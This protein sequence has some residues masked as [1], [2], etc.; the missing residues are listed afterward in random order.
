MLTF[1]L[2][3]PT[4]KNALNARIEEV[5][6]QARTAEVVDAVAS[7]WLTRSPGNVTQLSLEDFKRELTRSLQLQGLPRPLSLCYDASTIA[8]TDRHPLAVS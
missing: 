1:P 4:R 5:H 3:D 7:R 8:D 2:Y 6:T